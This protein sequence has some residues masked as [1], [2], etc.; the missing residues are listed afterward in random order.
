MEPIGEDTPLKSEALKE[1]SPFDPPLPERKDPYRFRYF[2]LIE[3]GQDLNYCWSF[4]LKYR[5]SFISI[6]P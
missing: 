5:I 3:S 6:P 4:K 1:V 2:P